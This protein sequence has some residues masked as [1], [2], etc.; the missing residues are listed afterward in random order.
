M[1]DLWQQTLG[2]NDEMIDSFNTLDEAKA[3]G[4]ALH[5]EPRAHLSIGWFDADGEH[6]TQRRSDS[7]VWKDF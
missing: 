1:Y 7:E 6:G 5:G 3:A 4:D 2:T